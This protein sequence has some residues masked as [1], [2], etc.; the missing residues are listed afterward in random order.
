MIAILLISTEGKGIDAV[1][2]MIVVDG[3]QKEM[4]R[5][6]KRLVDVNLSKDEDA[7]PE[8][9]CALL[10]NGIVDDVILNAGLLE[11]DKLAFQFV[12]FTL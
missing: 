10:H 1:S 8:A 12:L 3:S 5:G 7:L 11:D 9:T 6:Y 2:D 4:V